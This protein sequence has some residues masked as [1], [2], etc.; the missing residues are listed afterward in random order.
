MSIMWAKIQNTE[1][2]FLQLGSN[3][4]I[5]WGNNLVNGTL[6]K[7]HEAQEW[8][9]AG[10]TPVLVGLAPASP[11]G[12]AV[13]STSNETEVYNLLHPNINKS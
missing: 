7:D 8:I 10:F 11:V 6:L 1:G 5:T 4:V 3:G 2:K 12:R 13:Y 9:A